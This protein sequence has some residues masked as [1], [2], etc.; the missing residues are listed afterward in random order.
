[1]EILHEKKQGTCYHIFDKKRLQ[2][3]LFFKLIQPC[4]SMLSL[5]KIIRIVNYIYNITFRLKQQLKGRAIILQR[6]EIIL[7]FIYYASALICKKRQFLLFSLLDSFVFF[8]AFWLLR[9]TGQQKTLNECIS[10]YWGGG[11]C[12][13]QTFFLLSI[14]LVLI[15]QSSPDGK[16]RTKPKSVQT[17]KVSNRLVESI[18]LAQI[19]TLCNLNPAHFPQI[20]RAFGQTSPLHGEKILQNSKTQ[21]RKSNLRFP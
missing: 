21:K 12:L 14:G 11:L 7:L 10:I 19:L 8:L 6:N 2:N 9:P 16:I 17:N 20:L 15:V 13:V 4:K 18:C 1:M 3:P 5:Q